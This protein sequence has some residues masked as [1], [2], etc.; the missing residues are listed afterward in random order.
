MNQNNVV[1]VKEQ[2]DQWN[3][4]ESSEIGPHTNIGDWSLTKEQSQ[5][6]VAKI[7]LSTNDAKTT[8]QS[9]AKK[10]KNECRHRVYTLHKS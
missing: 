8:G 2:S 1:L 5:Y 10:K 9:H 3:R 7:I 4:V 6:N